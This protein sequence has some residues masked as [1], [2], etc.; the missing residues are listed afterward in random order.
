MASGADHMD[1]ASF[2]QNLIGL[3]LYSEILA[4]LGLVAGGA[5]GSFSSFFEWFSQIHL[6]QKK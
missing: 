2:F 6:I 4:R 3:E 5:D 1:F